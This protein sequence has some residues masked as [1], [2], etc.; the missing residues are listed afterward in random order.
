[1]I[2]TTV[3]NFRIYI[4]FFL[5]LLSSQLLSTLLEFFYLQHYTFTEL[6]CQ[7]QINTLLINSVNK[8]HPFLLY[9]SCVKLV[10]NMCQHVRRSGVPLSIQHLSTSLKQ[11]LVSFTTATTP[12][13]MTL[14]LGGW[15]AAQEGSWG[16]WWNWDTSEFFGLLMLFVSL[17]LVHQVSTTPSFIFY[18]SLLN[19]YALVIILFFTLLQINFTDVSHNFGFHNSTFNNLI[20]LQVLF[21][22]LSLGYLVNVKSVYNVNYKYFFLSFNLSVIVFFLPRALMSFLIILNVFTILIIPTLLEFG[23]LLT[24]LHINFIIVIF[25]T[26]VTCFLANLRSYTSNI[27]LSVYFILSPLTL[28][29]FNIVRF[30]R[31][32]TCAIHACLVLCI[33]L[34]CYFTHFSIVV[35]DLLS[36][37]FFT[38]ITFSATY[39]INNLQLTTVSTDGSSS[40][41]VKLLKLKYLNLKADT[42]YFTDLIFQKFVTTYTNLVDLGLCL[43]TLTFYI[44]FILI[45]C[46]PIIL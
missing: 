6:Y 13:I 23:V 22:I 16:G 2:L 19:N 40:F 3:Y 14:L 33:F 20:L 1:M 44:G 27:Y 31:N 15:W 41:G 38:N 39:V 12:L 7:D 10:V 37:A 43:L 5:S 36:Q 46:T 21:L 18:N 4:L 32:T 9:L 8:V 28:I 30:G 42:T 24:H 45:I 26:L 35:H 29:F 25:T 11:Y 17:L 34:H